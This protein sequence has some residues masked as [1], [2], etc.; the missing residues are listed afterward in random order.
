M[1]NQRYSKA[2]ASTG[3]DSPARGHMSAGL[4]A[5]LLCT[6]AVL[7]TCLLAAPGLA[8]AETA[9][10]PAEPQTLTEVVV[11]A[12][13]V[14]EDVQK[15]PIAMS[16]YDSKALKLAAIRDMEG[17]SAVAPDV[18]FSMTEGQPIITVRGMS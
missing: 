14:K 1:N 18:N 11:T 4:R 3:G 16:V 2:Q 15:T 6:G 8:A 13:H 12:Q 9:E 17:L 5:K 10:A 7:T